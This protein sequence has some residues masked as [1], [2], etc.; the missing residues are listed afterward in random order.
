MARV[1]T[2]YTCTCGST[3]LMFQ[4]KAIILLWRSEFS[5][6][7]ECSLDSSNIFLTLQKTL[8]EGIVYTCTVWFSVCK[9]LYVQITLGVYWWRVVVAECLIRLLSHSALPKISQWP[10]TDMDK[11]SSEFNTHIYNLFGRLFEFL[12]FWIAN[13][14]WLQ[15]PN[16][17]EMLLYKQW[18]NRRRK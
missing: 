9:R 11:M 15:S 5:E 3:H 4:N 8:R 6:Q 7:L 2:E 10:V 1:L 14:C 13:N 17:N 18:K 16:C 12:H